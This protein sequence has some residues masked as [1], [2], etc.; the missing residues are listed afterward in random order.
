[1][2]NNSFGINTRSALLQPV[3]FRAL[4]ISF[5]CSCFIS[6]TSSLLHSFTPS[7]FHSRFT[8]H[9]PRSTTHGTPSRSKRSSELSKI[10]VQLRPIYA[11]QPFWNQHVMESFAAGAL[12]L[13]NSLIPLLL[14]H[15]FPS[16]SLASAHFLQF[17]VYCARPL[18]TVHRSPSTI[19]RSRFTVLGLPR[20]FRYIWHAAF[21]GANAI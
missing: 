9:G 17:N 18:C 15:F 3:H 19:H 5:P 21:L 7:L 20:R 6:F 4:S 1:M 16:R 14:F 2:P 11:P 12:S 13:L 8:T 10:G